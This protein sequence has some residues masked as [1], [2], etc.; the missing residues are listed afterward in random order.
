M[1]LFF[2][3]GTCSFAPHVVLREAGIDAEL[4][5]VNLKTRQ[6]A[7]GR[8]YLAINP[9][10]YVP[11]I[12]LDDGSVL[13][14]GPAIVQYLG[15]RNPASG[16]VPA[17][18]SPARYR[19]QEWLGFINSELHKSYSTLFHPEL[20]EASHESA[21]ANIARRLAVIEPVLARQPWLLGEQF[22]AADAYLY[23]VVNWSQ[24]TRVSLSDWPALQAFVARVAARPAVQAAQQ[25]EAELKLG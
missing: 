6:T 3:P 23:T 22:S 24:W 15:D 14:E 1:K 13:T 2:A 19:L 17:A 5:R 4:V 12:E 8:D 10:G 16:I 20:P 7:D 25:V 18:G 9:K 11:A 21:R